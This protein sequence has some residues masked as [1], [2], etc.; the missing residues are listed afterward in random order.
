V[1]IQRR[2]ADHR[3]EHGF[4]PTI[5]IGLHLAEA[6]RQRGDYVGG[7][8]HVAARIGDLGDGDEIVISEQLIR[9]SGTLPYGLARTR[10][11]EL[12]GVKGPTTVSN[13]DW[14]R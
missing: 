4:S 6:T 9:G 3:L 1:D 12:K 5:R 2:L 14:R 8:V 13:V 7:G 10:D 11:V